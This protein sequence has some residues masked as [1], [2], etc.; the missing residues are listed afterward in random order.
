MSRDILEQT[1]YYLRLTIPNFKKTESN[2]HLVFTCPACLHDSPTC[3][4]KENTLFKMRCLKCSDDLGD[5]ADV[6]A[7]QGE[8]SREE[9]LK[10]IAS[11]LNIE[12]FSNDEI[13][14][15]VD[16]YKT[17]NFDLV[18]ITRYDKFPIEKEWTTK[19]HTDVKEWSN[20]LTEK[21]NIGVKTGERSNITVIDF[22]NGEIPEEIKPFIG[23]TLTQKTK[24]GYHL[25]YEYDK[26]LPSTRIEEMK[27]DI[28][29]NGKQCVIFPSEVKGHKRVFVGDLKI[30]K[31]P[32]E[33][34]EF[35]KSKIG[36]APINKTLSEQ[37]QEDIKT[38]N[39]K[40][41]IIPEGSRNVFMIR[42]GG[43]L[44]KELN[45]SQ[46]G[47]VL[48]IMNKN[49]CKPSLQPKEFRALLNQLDKY[50]DVDLNE[51][52][53]KILHYLKLIEQAT[54]KDIQEITGEKK[55]VVDK[56]LATLLKE[57]LILRRGR[58]Y[59]SIKKADWS[60]RFPA[61]SA[62]LP[63]KVPYFNDVGHFNWADMLLLGGRSKVGKTTTA[64]NF[65]KAFV[66]Q[67]I[68]PYYIYLES[69]SRFQKT[70][71]HLGMKE[72]DFYS[73]FVSDP[74]KIELEKNAVTIIDWLLVTEKNYTD[75]V[76]K[77]F[78][79]QLNK[80]QGFL[81]VFMQLKHDDSWF[82]PNMAL[83]FPALAA[84]Y[85]YDEVQDKS[86][87]GT[88]GRWEI[89]AIREPKAFHKGAAIPCIYDWTTK[90]L[91]PVGE[92]DLNG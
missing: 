27:I 35:L 64:L 15:I 58:F 25:F 51:T 73:A 53:L 31:M 70:A 65:V 56:I 36:K 23:N 14:K 84:R 78:V 86:T 83:Q 54:S 52:S 1:I 4:F 71:V 18:P 92:N 63:F 32:N 48:D 57:G 12:Y 79:E 89:D 74:T 44:R 11:V 29:N 81:I 2:G 49:F 13:K 46:V 39:F 22:D 17:S 72:G 69:G 33:L 3:S 62:T 21:L 40:S 77:S 76:M 88:R 59:H 87:Y 47:Y 8:Y 42:L 66:D 9:A 30:E 43:I 60:D 91:K 10:D 19:S 90:Q 38:E 67:G 50:T 26:D 6:M 37:L 5:I 55:V 68:K 80:T 20:W 75:T 61:M 85:I 82:A 7:R 41:D 16:F 34:K 24:Q 45:L 28:L